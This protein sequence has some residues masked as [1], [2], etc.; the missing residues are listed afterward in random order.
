ML[1]ADLLSL[2]VHARGFGVVHLHAVHAHIPLPCFRIAGDDAGQRDKPAG[3]LRPALQHRKIQQRKIIFLDDFFARARRH[4]LGKKFPQVGQHGQHLD[5]VQQALRRLHVHERVNAG[6]DFIQ[7]IH[8]QRHLHAP[9]R[10]KLVDEQ[11][12]TGVSFDV[13]KQQRRAAGLGGAASGFGDAVGDL[14]DFED[15]IYFGAHPAQLARSVEG[16]D[17]ISEVAIGHERE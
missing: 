15:R 1:G 9:R 10:A 11:R 5:F 7:R 2:P 8:F 14:G 3:I 16:G 4:L 12:H 17:P 6:G 13:F